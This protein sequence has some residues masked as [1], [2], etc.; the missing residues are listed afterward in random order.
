MAKRKDLNKN[1][2]HRFARKNAKQRKE[3]VKDIRVYFLIVCEGAETEPNYF[4]SFP[5]VVNGNVHELKFGGGGISTIKVVNEAIRIRDKSPLIYDRVWAVFDRDSFKAVDFNA[6]IEKGMQNG[7][8]CAWSNE[9]FELWY[10][11]HFQ[12]RN[13]PMSRIDYRNA[14]TKAVNAKGEKAFKYTKDAK[15]MYSIMQKY[16]NETKAI[17]NA[18]KLNEIHEE[19]IY[20]DHNPCTTVYQLVLELRGKDEEFNNEIEEKYGEGK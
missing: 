15:N 13:T 10:L 16:G 4:R 12:Y 19:K 5:T 6:A 14:I 18:K 3:A 2:T 20:A 9:A 11:L 17:E 7:V 1:L 8:H